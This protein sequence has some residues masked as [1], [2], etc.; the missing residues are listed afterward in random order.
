[1]IVVGK[2]LHLQES[3]QGALGLNNG[4]RCRCYPSTFISD[5]GTF[6]TLEILSGKSETFPFNLVPFQESVSSDPQKTK[7]IFEDQRKLTTCRRVQKCNGEYFSQCMEK[8]TEKAISKVIWVGKGALDA[9]LSQINKK[10][11]DCFHFQ[12]HQRHLNYQFSNYITDKVDRSRVQ[13]PLFAEDQRPDPGDGG[14][15]AYCTHKP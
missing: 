14:N 3:F 5:K 4:V 8:C 10:T 6:N 2:I 15:R 1:M 9:I 7:P 11:G 12:W 13:P